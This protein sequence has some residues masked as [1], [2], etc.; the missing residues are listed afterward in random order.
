[1]SATSEDRR[2]AESLRERILY[3]NHRY[4]VLD[5]PEVPDAE[6]DRL[7]RELK[8]LES[9]H[10]DLVTPDSPTQRV[11]AAP[12]PEF[13]EVRHAIPMISLDN[14]M[15][16]EE[17]VDFHRRVL[18]GLPGS[19]DPLYVAEP[20]LDGL[21]ISLRYEGGVLVLAATRGDG[22]RGEDVTHTART[23]PSIPLSLIGED[24]PEVLEVRGEVYMT[25][26]GFE[27]LN[28][29]ILQR[30]ERPFANPRNAAAGSLRQLDPRVTARRP[31]RF[32]CYGWGELSVSP[33]ATQQAMLQRLA[34]WGIPISRELKVVTG[35]D[36]CRDYFEGLGRRR[37]SLDF[38]IDGVV[39]KLDRLADQVRLGATSH[40][41]RWAIARKFPAQEEMT[42]VEAVEFQ[43]GRTGAVTPVARLQPVQVG[44]VT[45]SN[46]TLHN[47]DE[48]VR[49]D[50]R[51]GDTVVVRRAGDVIP[52]VVR[53]VA[54][55][56]PADARQVMLPSHCPVCG[57]DV[58]RPEGEAVARCT[59]GLF[60]PAQ[61]KE[62]LKHFAS[63]KAMDIDGLGDKLIEQLVDL[64]WIHE[65]ADLYGL[66]RER[67]VHLER[68]GEKSAANLVAAL[69]RSKETSF[70][71]FIHALGIREV[72]ETTARA[73]AERFD[74]IE[75]LMRARVE[76]FVQTRGVKGV[77]VETANAL[78]AFLAEHPDLELSGDLTEWLAGL[79]IRGLTRAR[80]EAL[81][82]RFGDLDALRAAELE[83]LYLNS[84]RLVEG[85][86]PVVAAHIAGFFA[87]DHNREAIGRLLAAGV[88]WDSGS[89]TRDQAP[90]QPLE[91]KTIVITGSLSQ[92]R[93]AIKSRLQQ[94]G[95]KVTSSV[96][97]QTDYLLAGEDAGSKLDKARGLG[98]E[99]LDETA[100]SALIDRLS[101]TNPGVTS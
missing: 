46:A 70:A 77:G 88:R 36:G 59:G 34:A 50:V 7:V 79:G 91:G 76:D 57:S 95:A 74:G 18:S 32:C 47:M 56:R 10:P 52:E 58:I 86:G 71:R 39:F 40:H 8:Q 27:R 29:E 23:I 53:V 45:V 37:E 43:V 38:E 49:K 2:R 3:H 30:G 13:R 65:P 63:R 26:A 12:R 1:M 99:I 62:S 14:A 51:I 67:L 72:G 90:A 83:D 98:V 61:R 41:P 80:A 35:L 93:D 55:R 78:H 48:V 68:M 25:R 42:R 31:L 19:D 89:E 64:D 44:G 54:E 97:R 6:Y 75:P 60:C 28:A 101:Q 4:Y 15:S 11:G 73:L 9:E 87:Q 21:A 22:T 66:T 96:S 20:K 100:L 16:D 69:E 85:V 94:L 92:P 33:E 5:D 81:A 17:L 24:R 84:R 82:E